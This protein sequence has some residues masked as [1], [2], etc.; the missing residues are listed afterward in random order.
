MFKQGVELE[1]EIPG[2]KY[3]YLLEI[4]STLSYF[5]IVAYDVLQKTQQL[6]NKFIKRLSVEAGEEFMSV[7]QNDFRKI[8][9]CI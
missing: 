6:G 1:S 9:E 7:N 2:S 4:S 3:H 8:V 5:F